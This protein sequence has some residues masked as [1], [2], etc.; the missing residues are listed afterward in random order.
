M[1][2]SG[3]TVR[4]LWLA[5]FAAAMPVTAT[6][7]T[8]PETDAHADGQFQPP[9][10][11][12][13][14]TRTLRKL[15]PDGKQVVTRRTYKLRIAPNENGFRIDGKLVDVAVEAPEKLRALAEIERKRPDTGMFP[16]WLDRSGTLLPGSEAQPGESTK[17]AVELVSKKLEAM[18]LTES[19]KLQAQAFVSQFRKRQGRSPWPTDLFHPAPGLRRETRTIS[20]ADGTQG[21]VTIDLDAAVAGTGLLSSYSRTVTTTLDG[22]S[23]VTYETWT[24][25]KAD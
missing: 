15:L 12:V 21:Q 6:A 10:S 23:R 7:Q 24:L 22:E 25:G 1:I 17:E 4:L 16:M 19:S 13:L 18:D 5:A 8:K 14:L 3:S 9:G 11:P 2:R 20:L